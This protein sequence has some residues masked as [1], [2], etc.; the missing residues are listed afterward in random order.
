MGKNKFLTSG[1]MAKARRVSEKALRA[2]LQQIAD[3][4]L[5]LSLFQNPGT[6]M[7]SSERDLKC[8]CPGATVEPGLS[9]PGHRAEG[10]RAEVAAWAKRY[11]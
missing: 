8:V 9:I 2:T 6:G 10:S 3:L 4:G 1:Q 5:P 7:G 11:V